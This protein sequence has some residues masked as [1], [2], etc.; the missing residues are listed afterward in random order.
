M[1]PKRLIL[2]MLMALFL[3]TVWTLDVDGKTLWTDDGVPICTATENQLD[4]HMIGDGAGGV[5]LTWG[6]YRPVTD[7]DVYVQRINA[8][9]DTLWT[10]DGVPICTAAYSQSYPQLLGDGSGGA[11][12]FWVDDRLGGDRDIYAQRI[13]AN[14]DTL[15]TADGKPICTAVRDQTNPLLIGDDSGGAIIAWGE[16]AQTTSWDVRAQRIDANGDTLWAADGV[17]ICTAVYMQYLA[18]I[19]SDGSGGAIITWSDYRNGADFNIYAQ[20]IDG[21]G[22]T[23]W[24]ADGVPICTAANSQSAPQLVTDGSGGAIITW[25]DWRGSDGDIYAQR[26]DASGAIQWTANGA[27]I[28]TTSNNQE[29]PEIAA[30][31]SGG[32]IITWKDNRGGGS[33]DI[34]AQRIDADGV[35]LWNTNGVPICTASNS[36]INPQIAADG[37]GGAVITWQDYRGGTYDIYAQRVDSNGGTLEPADG[38]AICTVQGHQEYPVIF[39]N[40]ADSIFI[41]WRDKRGD[42][43]DI[44]AQRINFVPAPFITSITDVPEDQGRQVAVFWDRSYLD[45]PEIQGITHYSIWRRYPWG[46]KIESLGL[47][48]D[49]SLVKD[50]T[51]RAYRRIE[52]EDGSGQPK[53]E[54]W[55]YMGSV[56]AH[57]FEVYVSVQPTFDDSSAG[58]IP[59]CSFF[60]T[61]HGGEPFPY[62]DSPP[63]SG[64][65]V[66]DVS[67]AKTIMSIAHGGGKE[68]KGSLDLSWEQVTTG[69]DGSPETGSI[70]YNVYCDT[71]AWFTP[72]AGN[73]LT[74]TQNLSYSHSD[75]RIGD[76]ATDLFYL[77]TAVDGSNNQSET[78]NRTGESDFQLKTTTG[79]D[80]TWIAF[81]L[82]DASLTMASDLEAYIE[83]HSSPAADC[84]T[85]SEWNPTAQ[86]YTNYT[87][88]PVPAGD[89]PLQPGNAYR[90]EMSADAIWTLVGDVLPAD[91]V[92]FQLKATT[93]TDYTWISNPMHL[94]GLLMASDLEAHIEANSSPVTDC[95]TISEW[96]ATAQTY[97]N[98]TTI[99]VPAGDFPVGPGRAYRVEV[100]NE[101]V[102]PYA[103]KGTREFQRALHSR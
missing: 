98:Y 25:S 78:S 80:Y 11:F 29:S 92:S 19:I 47:A 93:G 45:T 12:I 101:A 17:P 84:Y 44:Y 82:G 65:S 83:A 60:I 27:A 1:C 67:P 37:S 96:N 4:I 74:T 91:S 40:G 90:V 34:Y 79:T 14:G 49:G 68:A 89:F 38:E 53:T 55:E 72:E 75:A 87:T 31:G 28:C 58:G 26:I 2:T 23:L 54:Y 8:D 64:Y 85:I 77:V 30:D 100:S 42:D 20:R 32:A 56:E 61:A 48:W 51:Q 59:Y 24:A 76:P 36:Q 10:A 62:W 46:P 81:C 39:A 69:E 66:D 86:T 95:Y 13:N 22:D 71:T 35:S 43:F 102:W 73:L 94:D 3:A 57:L 41:A 21:N 50:L 18:G 16:D 6:D 5:I 52:K 33:S 7:T 70:Q 99:P 103:G 15:W 88:I 9:G 97:T 63:D